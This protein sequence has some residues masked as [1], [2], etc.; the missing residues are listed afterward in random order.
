ML[1][2][3]DTLLICVDL[4]E[5]VPNGSCTSRHC[6]GSRHLVAAATAACLGSPT[7]GLDAKHNYDPMGTDVNTAIL[8][9]E[10]TFVNW[11]H[12]GAFDCAGDPVRVRRISA[13]GQQEPGSK[14][15]EYGKCLVS[16][17]NQH[18]HSQYLMAMTRPA[19]G[20]QHMLADEHL[21][22]RLV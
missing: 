14:D 7:D 8:P 13:P 16:P 9:D 3:V 20:G 5:A 17:T 19:S 18:E 6:G 4:Y 1:L 22:T 21:H 15:A 11:V 2:L 10:A 12:T